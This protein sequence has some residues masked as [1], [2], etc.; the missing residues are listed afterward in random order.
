MELNGKRACI[1]GAG[2]SLS[3]TF[4]QEKS[5]LRLQAEAFFAALEDAGL[6]RGDID[7]F[8]TAH[9]YP[10]GVDY[11]E[12]TTTLGLDCRYV[13]QAWSHGRWASTLLAHAAFAVMSGLA[14]YVAVCNTQV[15]ARGYGHY[16]G[17]GHQLHGPSE[18]MRDSGGG[19]GE[20]DVHGIDTPGSGTAL[21]AQRYFDRYGA[22]PEDLARVTV[23]A[24]SFGARN[25]MAV[26][27]H[28]PLTM[29][30]YF[31]EPVIAGPFRRSDYMVQNEGS[32]CLIV[33]TTDRAQDAARPAPVIAG[34]QGVTSNRDTHHLFSRPGLGV[35]FAPQYPYKAPRHPVYDMAGVSMADISG[36][37]CYDSFSSNVW[38]VLE[39]LG[40]CGEGE[41]P[42]YIK[43]NG[44]GLDDKLPVNTNGGL[45][46]EGDQTGYAHL[47][48]MVRQLRG[49]CG[50]RQIPQADVLQ[51]ASP[52]GD[53]LIL[54]NP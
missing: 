20:W 23:S 37:Y 35:G 4:A 15:T 2:T 21:V 3:F 54:T 30:T 32:T 25:P 38:M 42:E 22:T 27:G 40:F 5:P 29:Q 33:T 16:L 48:E 31:D 28:K 52:W 18:G 6:Q 12:F 9:G 7:G 36:L 51:W 44:L 34:I 26:L 14:D 13:D 8:A 53:S 47:V 10:T 46:S 19:H 1:V 49:E 11:E 17:G 39:R 43:Q 24:R 50:P 45:L 41:A